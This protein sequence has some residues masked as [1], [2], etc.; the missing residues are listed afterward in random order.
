[1]LIA[2]SNSVRGMPA[3]VGDYMHPA[4]NI[5]STSCWCRDCI[6]Y[7]LVQFAWRGWG[8]PASRRAGLSC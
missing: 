2:T 1:M 7:L 3:W 8:S 4:N 5:H 6:Q